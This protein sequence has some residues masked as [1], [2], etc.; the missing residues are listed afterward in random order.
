MA[1]TSNGNDEDGAEVPNSE[2]DANDSGNIN[3]EPTV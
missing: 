3:D 2:G 1:D